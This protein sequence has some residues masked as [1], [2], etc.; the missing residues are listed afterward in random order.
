MTNSQPVFIILCG[1]MLNTY[2]RSGIKQACPLSHSYS[3][4]YWKRSQRNWERKRNKK[5]SKQERKKNKIAFFCRL[6]D[7]TYRKSQRLTNT[8]RNPV[9]TSIIGFQD[10]KST[11][12]KTLEYI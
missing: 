4:E 10:A 9:K 5:T 3:T 11:Y 12:R 8:A 1:K 7:L 6:Y 2:L